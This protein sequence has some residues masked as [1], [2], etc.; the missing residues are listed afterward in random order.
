MERQTRNDNGSSGGVSRYD[1]QPDRVL[2]LKGISD[3]IFSRMNLAQRSQISASQCLAIARAM[4]WADY[5]EDK[6]PGRGY[7][8]RVLGMVNYILDTRISVKGRGRNDLVTSISAIIGG[9]GAETGG[10]KDRI[11]RLMN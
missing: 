11:M 2:E 9:V 4:A 3:E 7:G 8:V 10:L 1:R 5:L 6:Y